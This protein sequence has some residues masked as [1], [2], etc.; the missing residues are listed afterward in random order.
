MI[1]A[2]SSVVWA[3]PSTMAAPLLKA[4]SGR[5]A[6]EGMTTEFTA[7]GMSPDETAVTRERQFP[8][9]P[10]P[11]HRAR[12]D[13]SRSQDRM[14]R[15]YQIV[16]HWGTEPNRP[17]NQRLVVAPCPRPPPFINPNTL[18]VSVVSVRSPYNF[19]GWVKRCHAWWAHV[20]RH[21]DRLSELMGNASRGDHA[22]VSP[23]FVLDQCFGTVATHSPAV[24]PP[25]PVAVVVGDSTA[26]AASTRRGTGGGSGRGNHGGRSSAAERRAVT[27]ASP[28]PSPTS[29]GVSATEARRRRP[30]P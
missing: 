6:S 4:K 23:A 3:P 25:Q 18:L 15:W 16:E 27:F 5:W 30:H 20:S 26:P 17:D 29:E 19:E 21:F 28:D 14:M 8:P 13:P 9:P 10:P 2:A 11:A 24:P 1:S 7:G 22:A 12:D